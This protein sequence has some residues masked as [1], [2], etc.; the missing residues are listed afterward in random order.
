MRGH[1]PRRDIA[2]EEARNERAWDQRHGAV[3]NALA[4]RRPS[5]VEAAKKRT[6]K[7]SALTESELIKL[8]IG[9]ESPKSIRRQGAGDVLS[10]RIGVRSPGSQ[11]YTDVRR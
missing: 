4:R 6:R 10:P 3:T 1:R 2:T 5:R 9:R 8:M 7:S 11:C